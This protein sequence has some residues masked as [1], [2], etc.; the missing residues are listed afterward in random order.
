MVAIDIE[1]TGLDPQRDAIIE[2]AAVRFN[3]HR[4]EGEWTKLIN[5]G[6]PIPR[7]I[8]QLTRITDQMVAHAPPLKAVIQELADF[9]G[10]DPVVGHNIR[11][12]LGFL[13]KQKILLFNKVI[14]TYEMA[15]IVLPG[16]SRYNL[17]TLGLTLNSLIPNSHRALDDARLTQAVYYS[18][19]QKLLELPIEI[20][21]E[22]VRMAEGIEW[23]GELAFQLVLQAKGRMPVEARKVVQDDYGLLFGGVKSSPPLVP[24]ETPT[25]L[26]ADE[27]AAQIEHGGP[28]SRYFDNFESRPQQLEMLRAVANALSNSQHFMVE[29]GTGTGKSFA[30]LIPAVEWAIRNSMRVV[31]STNTI[32][33]QDQLI[34]KDIPD[35]AAALGSEVRATVVK[36]RGNYLCPR[37]FSAMRKV[38]PQNAEEV[39][40]LA[41]TLVWLNAGGSGDRGEINLNGPQEREVWQRLSAEDEGCK[42]EVCVSRMGG[43][44]PFYRTH[45]DAQSSHIL[46]VNHALLLADVVTGNRVLPEYNYLIV[47]EAH[48]LESATTNAL[49]FRLT[50]N[51]F[52]RMLREIG[53]ISSGLLGRLLTLVSHSLPPSDFAA[54]NMA[55]HKISDLL[56]RL[57]NEFS[58][59]IFSLD[60]FMDEQREGQPVSSYGQQCRVLPA[61]RTLPSWSN[62]EIAW[63]SCQESLSS[64]LKLVAELQ[65]AISDSLDEVPEEL[66]DT[67]GS[68]ASVYRR[69][70]EAQNYLEA[71]VNHPDMNFVYWVEIMPNSQRLAL[72]V[73]PLHIGPLMEKYLWHEKASVI[74][75]SA[76]LTTNNEF[77]YIRNRL[78][79]D[80]ADE[81]VLGSPFD[82]ENATLLYLVN[83]IPEPAEANAYQREVESAI[84]RLAKATGGRMLALFTSYAQLKKTAQAIGPA[85]VDADI[86]VYE[87]GEGASTNTLL[88]TFREAEKAVLLGTRAFWEGVDIPGEALSVLVIVKLPFDVPSDPI[89]AA[90]SET[91]EDPFNEY[92][93]PE[94][95]LRFRQ[96]FGR[97]IRTQSD[98]GVVVILD[99]RVLTK[100][101]GRLFLDSLPECTRRV[102]SSLD[103]PAAAARWLNI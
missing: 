48:H 69:L 14:D 103:L 76:T 28:F 51:D 60:S 73:A 94:A 15:A 19:S 49:S 97:L 91:F 88:E 7:L 84:I 22:V 89:I 74:L 68:L 70:S 3:G 31:I 55:V 23:D 57:E 95:I 75:T 54:L 24:V 79:A 85:M 12:D 102:A 42:T 6:R 66:E 99:K 20:L 2:I 29:A 83:D 101:Y 82:Y 4:V 93:L 1:T 77:D 45:Q 46:V 87:Q 67:L 13:Q 53:S 39:R 43:A 80:E 61:T 59:L 10:S 38:G 52:V 50:Q 18:L 62:V 98:R 30:Y 90:R 72:Q 9:V 16:N 21:A 33:L 34:K 78:N 40:I 8:T 100:K 92:N 37:R 25:P 32:T 58:D 56:F 35:L 36:G 81:L 63:D 65:K 27:I 86:Q 41:K 64:A 17:G 11:F 71:L 26:D 5:P 47:D 96:G 44:C